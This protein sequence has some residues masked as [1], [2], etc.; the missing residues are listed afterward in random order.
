MTPIDVQCIDCGVPA[1]S[2]C[3]GLIPGRYHAVRTAWAIGAGAARERVNADLVKDAEEF[4]FQA[5]A[6]TDEE[7]QSFARRACL[8]TAASRLLQAAAAT[9]QLEA[10]GVL[11]DPRTR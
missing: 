8:Y 4:I 2:P 5:R 10:F 6:I 9:E 7:P 1:Q 11:P 3:A